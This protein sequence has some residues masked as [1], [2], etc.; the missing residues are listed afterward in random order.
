MVPFRGTGMPTL[1]A[2]TVA[3]LTQLTAT[4][5]AVADMGRTPR[6]PQWCAGRQR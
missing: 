3:R 6:G 4:S 5:M 1:H 2:L